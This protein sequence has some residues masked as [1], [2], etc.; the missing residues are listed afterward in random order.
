[1]SLFIWFI[2]AY[3][4]LPFLFCFYLFTAE[5]ESMRSLVILYMWLSTNPMTAKQKM[6]IIYFSLN[7]SASLLWQWLSVPSLLMHMFFICMCLYYCNDP[8]L[9][10]HVVIT[11]TKQSIPKKTHRAQVVCTNQVCLSEVLDTGRCGN[12]M[13]HKCRHSNNSNIA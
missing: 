9:I 11:P 2:T 1:M 3:S 10:N 13:R 4:S 8:T 7:T 6:F 12:K 5:D